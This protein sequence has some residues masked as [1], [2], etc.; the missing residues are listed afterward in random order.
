MDP[1]PWRSKEAC[2]KRQGPLPHLAQQT[3]LGADLR[4]KGFNLDPICEII[5]L[6]PKR[7][8]KSTQGH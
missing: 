5:A 6:K 4:E 1:Q 3:V 2:A 7:A 8:R